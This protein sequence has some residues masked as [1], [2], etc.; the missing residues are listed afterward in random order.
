[1]LAHHE[2]RAGATRVGSP[3]AGNAALTRMGQHCFS[4]SSETMLLRGMMLRS[5][6]CLRNG[7]TENGQTFD[8]LESCLPVG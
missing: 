4:P 5:S 3:Q 1:L 2:S 8:R 6:Y 7:Q